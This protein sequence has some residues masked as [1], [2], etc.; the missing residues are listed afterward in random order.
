MNNTDRKKAADFALWFFQLN[1]NRIL[2][3]LR[4]QDNFSVV[5]VF[6]QSD[7]VGAVLDLESRYSSCVVFTLERD[8]Y[9]GCVCK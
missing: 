1:W 2:L 9:T 5:Y 6:L 3:T 7:F 8:V 4:Y